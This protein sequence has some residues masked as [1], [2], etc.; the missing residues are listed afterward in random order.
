MPST[1]Y[2]K[3]LQRQPSNIRAIDERGNH[4]PRDDRVKD[5]LKTLEEAKEMREFLERYGGARLRE[6]FWDMVKG[7]HPDA[8]ML[9]FL[10]ARKWNVD[11]AIA[12]IGSTAAF[13]ADNDVANILKGGELG[14]TSTKG[15][16]N[17]LTNGVSYIYG[18][19]H[20]G[21]PVEFIE[22]GRHFSHNQTQD[23]LC[24]A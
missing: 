15:G 16:M 9:R 7:E 21:E 24:V 20:A 3:P 19:T 23:E 11:R 10:R 17:I 4:I 1:A 22:V 6:I 5:E 2:G 12:V 14:L 13:R 8:V 18:A